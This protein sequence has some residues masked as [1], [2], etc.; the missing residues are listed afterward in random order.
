MTSLDT[1]AVQ[2]VQVDSYALGRS[3]PLKIVLPPGYDES[4]GTTYPVLY[5]LHPWGL[6]PHYIVSKLRIDHHLAAGVETGALPPMVIVLPTG[7][8]SFFVNAED[9]QG[10]DWPRLIDMENDF[11]RG[12]LDQYGQYGDYLCNEIIPFVEQHYAVR[13]ERAGRAIGGISMGGAAAAVHA[14]RDPAQFCALGIHSPALFIGPPEQNGPPWIFGV[15][16]D[17]F[18][19]Y[20]PADLAASVSPEV[21]PRIYLDVGNQ[22]MMAERVKHLHTALDNAGLVHTYQLR[23]GGHNKLYWEP[24]MPEYLAFYSAGWGT[25]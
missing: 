11:F 12:A 2:D 6:S 20:N 10:Y 14:F 3:M 18:A 8:K 9:P 7:E 24:N 19:A 21:Q 4:A 25:P 16:R 23:P 15:T 17:R 22:D 1:G 13:T 5:F